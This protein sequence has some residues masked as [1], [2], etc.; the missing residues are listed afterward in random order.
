[1]HELLKGDVTCRLELKVVRE[2]LAHEL[3]NFSLKGDQ[4]LCKLDRILDQ[5]LVVYDFRAPFLDVRIH[6][7]N[8]ETIG[9]PVALE[10][11]EKQLELVEPL[12][13]EHVDAPRLF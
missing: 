11:P 13:L 2:G 10:D 7:V 6:F 1:M 12:L 5:P 4:L 9:R 3:I 8:D